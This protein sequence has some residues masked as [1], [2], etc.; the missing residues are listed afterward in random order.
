[1]KN[2]DTLRDL[3]VIIFIYIYS[4]IHKPWLSDSFDGMVFEDM[5][6]LMNM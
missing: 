1:M 4:N 6:F 3:T 5:H 2:L